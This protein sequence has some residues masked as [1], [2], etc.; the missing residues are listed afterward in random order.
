MSFATCSSVASVSSSKRRRT[1]VKPTG[2]SFETASVPRKSMSPSARTSPA[3]TFSAMAF[4]TAPSVTP[5]QP[6][7]AWS[8]M[9]PE[10]A[11]WPEPPVAGCRPATV[12]DGLVSTMAVTE[13]VSSRARALRISCAALGSSLYF[14]FSGAWRARSSSPVIGRAPSSEGL[15]QLGER[16][17]AGAQLLERDL[18]ERL[19]DRARDL[20]HLGRGLVDEEEAR[21][22][23]AA[24]LVVHE[25]AHGLVARA[26]VV[27][28]GDL[29]E[30]D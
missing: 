13:S 30:A 3:R 26:R 10:H 22:H 16:L 15:L 23:L 6:T 18:V 12:G 21:R 25:V 20:V 5:A 19:L 27:T 7:S 9:S 8:S 24:L 14:A 11:S 17:V 1:A 28:L 4:A 29:R 2:A